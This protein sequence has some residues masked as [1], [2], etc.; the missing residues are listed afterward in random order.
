MS[1]YTSD[2]RSRLPLAGGEWV[3]I[4]TRVRERAN[5]HCQAQVH[6]ALCNGIGSECDHITPGD[7]NSLDNLQWLNKHCHKL[8]TQREAARNNRRRAQLRRHPHETNP[9]MIS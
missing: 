5:N 3:R 9:G 4:R 8:K 7:D 2:R 6:S 1:W